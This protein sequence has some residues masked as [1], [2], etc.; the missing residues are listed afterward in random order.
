[1][2]VEIWSDIMCP[3]C[4]IGKQKFENA[5]EQFSNK[6]DIKIHWRSFQLDPALET[7]NTRNVYEYLAEKKGLDI[8][9]LK[10]CTQAD[11]GNCKAG[12]FGLQLR[13]KYPC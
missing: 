10:E 8:R 1:M 12:W 11:V 9:L 4:Y 3:F 7:D 6:N 5:L 2:Q 13:Y